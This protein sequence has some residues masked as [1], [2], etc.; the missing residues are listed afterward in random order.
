MS[1]V[2]RTRPDADQDQKRHGTCTRCQKR[3]Q[4]LVLA[5]VGEGE[6]CR[7]LNWVCD[8]CVGTLA[9]AKVKKEMAVRRLYNAALAKEARDTSRRIRQVL[10]HGRF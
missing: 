9:V 6:R 3:H 10:L 2:S 8:Q 1:K 7:E 4:D 5:C